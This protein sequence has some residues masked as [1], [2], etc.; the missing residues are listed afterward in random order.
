MKE[1]TSRTKAVVVTIKIQVAA[2]RNINSIIWGERKRERERLHLG[3]LRFFTAAAEPS[4]PELG[5][6]PSLFTGG[7]LVSGQELA[8]VKKK[9]PLLQLLLR[10]AKRIGNC[11]KCQT[12][13]K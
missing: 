11:P 10:N 13:N 4:S 5:P 2:E 8:S 9:T 12:R 3:L 1:Y 6:A 7:I